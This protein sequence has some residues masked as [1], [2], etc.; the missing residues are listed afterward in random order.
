MA[1]QVTYPGVYIDEFAPGAPIEGVGTGTAA[2]IGASSDGPIK[3]PVKVTSLDQFFATF[4]PQPLPGLFLW[5]A[6]RGFFQNGG[7]VCYIVRASNGDYAKLTIK[8]KDTKNLFTVIARQPGQSPPNPAITIKVERVHVLASANTPLFR[9]TVT[10][11]TVT[12]RSVKLAAGNTGEDFRAGDWVFIGAST[13]RVQIMRVM[14]DT[15]LLAEQPIGIGA[16]KTIHLAESPD[17]R[18]IRLAP[19]NPLAPG[20]LV[21]GTMLTV[22]QGVSTDTQIV[23]AAQPEPAKAG[24]MTYRVTLRQGLR[25][26]LELDPSGP[27]I[28]AAQSEEFNL[29]VAHGTV[30]TDYNSLSAEPSHQRYFVTVINQESSVVRV[31]LIEPPPFVKMP[32][33]LPFDLIATPLVGG[34]SENLTTLGDTDY[35]TAMDTLR[36]VDDVNLIATPGIASDAVQQGL[37]AHCEQTSDRFAVLDSRVGKTLFGADSIESQRKAVDSTRGYAALYYPWLRVPPVGPGAPALVPPSGHVCGVISR[38]DATRGVHK[39]PANE[40]VNGALG[41]ERTMSD[42]DQGQLNIQGVNVIRVFQSG[43]RPVIWGARTTATDRNWQ[44]VNIRRL[45]LFL[46]ESIQE[47]I[48]WAVFEPNNQGLWEKLRRTITD[49]LTR[50]WRDGALFGETAD[51]AFYVR[52][53]EAL[54]PDSSRALGRLYIEVG[55]RPSYPAEF[56]IVRIGIWYGGSSVTEG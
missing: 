28:P 17:R 15:I 25:I 45:F 51:K 50:V 36:N 42:I 23:E 9:P 19:T 18:T 46:E 33:N 1:V 11:D 30:K 29:Q 16:S 32:D 21:Q 2:F 37:I 39:A 31:E 26:P 54:N 6:V 14:S 41:V 24:K 10:F 49:F 52:I 5:Y 35:L 47:G 48:R 44:Y 40:I 8:N 53:D 56:I 13:V 55:V 12:G 22:T 34:A 27:N 38:S 43:A 7:Q 20:M 3:E 4:G